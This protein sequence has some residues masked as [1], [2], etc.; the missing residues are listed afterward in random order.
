MVNSRGKQEL[1]LHLCMWKKHV[2]DI[3]IEEIPYNW[4]SLSCQNLII[5]TWHV[6]ATLVSGHPKSDDWY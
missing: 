4:P 5:I 2:I 1:D 3:I 6:S